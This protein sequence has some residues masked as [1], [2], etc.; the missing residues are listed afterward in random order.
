MK[1]KLKKNNNNK[2]MFP[3]LFSNILEVYSIM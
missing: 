1:W 2:Y 3:V